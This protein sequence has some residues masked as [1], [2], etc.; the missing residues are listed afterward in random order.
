LKL[1]LKKRVK[2]EF[3]II[4]NTIAKSEAFIVG[5]SSIKLLKEVFADELKNV[6]IKEQ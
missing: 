5:L 3:P 6:E 1:D 4:K 2:V